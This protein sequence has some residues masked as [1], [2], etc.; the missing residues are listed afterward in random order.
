[1]AS[2]TSFLPRIAPTL[3]LTTSALY[4]R[5]RSL[6]RMKLLPTPEGRGRGSGAEATADTVAALLVSVLA[7][8]SLSES[9]VLVQAIAQSSFIDTAKGILSICPFTAKDQFV[10]AV[11]CTL[12]DE[13]LAKFQPSIIVSRGSHARIEWRRSRRTE[14]SL[15]GS[16]PEV[17]SEFL[18]REIR[19]YFP[20]L[21]AIKNEL[22]ASLSHAPIGVEK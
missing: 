4:E 15:F 2:L 9:E 6:V 11:A 5:Q 10:D 7:T 18:S 19:L 20:A 21:L 1:M 3:G 16:L 14:V 8:D 22:R 12:A 17:N 13:K